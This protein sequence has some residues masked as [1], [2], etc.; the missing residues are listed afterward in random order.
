MDKAKLYMPLPIPKPPWE[1]VTI[2]FFH[3]LLWTQK[4]KDS[5]MVV[6]DKS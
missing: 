6:E 1:D 5:K 4:L 2:D 3:G